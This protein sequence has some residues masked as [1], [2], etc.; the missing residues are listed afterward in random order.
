MSG[1]DQLVEIDRVIVDYPV[2]GWRRPPF[3]ALTDISLTVGAGETVGLV[4]ESGSGGK[5]H[6]VGRS[7]AWRP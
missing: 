5:P 1:H 6:W 7:S 2:K 3:R 4:G